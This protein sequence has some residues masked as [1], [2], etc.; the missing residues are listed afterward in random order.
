MRLRRWT[1]PREASRL[2]LVFAL[3]ALLSAW[4]ARV[5][6]AAD[7]PSGSVV[8]WPTMTP[9]GDDAASLPLH[10]PAPT[11]P[12][13]LARAQEL[14]A[15][16]RDAAQDLGLTLDV[17]DPGP[18]P[19]RTRDADIL[20][21]ASAPGALGA[22]AATWVVS[23]RLE[24]AGGEQFV[25]RILA[26]P[27]KGRELRV[28]VEN[29]KGADVAV[30][31]LV[32]L[33][34]LLSPQAAAQAAAQSL[35]ESQVHEAEQAGPTRPHSPGRAVLAVNG[36]LFGAY[37]AFSVQRASEND[38]PRLLYPL[39]ALGAGVGI[40]GTLLA[41]EE[42]D[43]GTGDAWMLAA[44][45][46]WGASAGLLIANGQSVQP[47]SDR[48]TWGAGGGL[49]GV[50]LATFA[51]TRGKADDGDAVL[52]HSGGAL[53]L[54]LGGLG[55][56]AYRGQTTTTATPNTGA[57]IGTAVGVV[58]MGALSTFV[59]VSPSRVML[60][61]LGA[62]L[63]TLAAAAAS[64][65]LVFENVTEGKARAFALATAGGTVIGGT[66]AWLLTPNVGRAASGGRATR[67]SALPFGGV[68]GGSATRAGIAPAY[69]AGVMGRF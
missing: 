22:D 64:S 41:S 6:N 57:G 9:A 38:D 3:V 24:H 21:R 59:Q 20:A 17:T 14:D 11:E 1:I 43:V 53:G 61:D 16:L 26:V 47:F 49:I 69:G 52:T 56:L 33:R 32:M 35:T 8:V 15:T 46:W 10:R 62:G 25:L 63:G 27:P 4:T 68:I 30:R 19:G 7:A 55:E 60:V 40:G 13:V 66:I 58:G 23:P 2:A 5:A 36:A 28:R 65:P 34:D 45:A 42:W 67:S 31:G 39:L 51:L 44:G 37:V 18:A 29:V 50:S 54:L 48:Y 12:A